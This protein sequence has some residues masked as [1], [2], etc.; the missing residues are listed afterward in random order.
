MRYVMKEKWL[1]FGDDFSIEDADGNEAFFVDGAAF[2]FGKKLSF[3]DMQGNE[4]AYIAQKLLSWGP[5]YEVWYGGNLAAVVK[6][7]L[8]TFFKSRFTVD[9]PGPDD[10]EAEGDFMAHEYSFTRHGHPVAQVSKQWFTWTDTYGIEV[11]EGE[12]D[13]LILACAVV[14]DLVCHGDRKR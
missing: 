9:V 5:T 8:F 11:G 3:Q 2:S 6:Q 14:I 1:S 10:L 4:L 12:D 13:V 7:K